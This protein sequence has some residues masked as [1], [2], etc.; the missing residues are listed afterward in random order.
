MTDPD[1]KPDTAAAAAD[2]VVRPPARRL[3]AGAV[4]THFHIFGP[5][6]AYPYAARR[7]YTPPDASVGAYRHLAETLG[8]AGAVI[9]QP[10]VYGSDNRRTLDAMAALGMPMRA[11]V[12][13]EE[14]VSDRELERLH[15]L[16]VRGV[17]INTVFSA[18]AGFA[19]ARRL[20]DRI[21]PLGWHIQFLTDI[22]AVA[23]LPGLVAPLSLPVVFD[24]LGHFDAALG[25]GWQGFADLV[26]LMADGLAW[27][28]LSG[29]YRS[30]R[31]QR[32]PYD[33]MRPIAEAMVARAPGQLLW[34]SDWPHPSIPVPMPNDGP[35]LDMT[36]GWMGDD[37][38]IE[39]ICVQTPRAF[40]G[41][42]TP[43]C[44][45]RNQA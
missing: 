33:D 28:K 10:S 40:Y 27:V 45:E 16:G 20:A 4:D 36:L 25:T 37:A 41:F 9:V 23:D 2:A 21:R 7:L 1:A 13:V 24:H 17:R 8:I 19:S 5:Q 38:A 31:R 3:P 29:A 11:V 15:G 14:D 44:A 26:G 42:D 35:L 30:T 32:L 12:V 43:T 34:G 39:A 6:D 18:E 22:S